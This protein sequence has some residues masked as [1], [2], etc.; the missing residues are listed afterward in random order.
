MSASRVTH[1]NVH[2][3]TDVPTPTPTPTPTYSVQRDVRREDSS[4][5]GTPTARSWI[6]A[7]EDDISLDGLPAGHQRLDYVGIR[8]LALCR[9]CQRL[10]ERAGRRDF[11]PSTRQAAR[12]CGLDPVKHRMQVHRLLVS[13]FPAEGWLQVVS[14]GTGRH[15][16]PANCY[17][18]TA[19]DHRHTSTGDRA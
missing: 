2:S 6:H 15:G 9:S 7:A 8:L 17:R 16:S 4:T 3:N 12:I 19:P 14:R 11:L 1:K 10:R 13:I 5:V 18:F